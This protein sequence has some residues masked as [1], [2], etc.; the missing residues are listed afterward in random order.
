MNTPASHKHTHR[1]RQ[2][3][4]AN[5]WHLVC[6]TCGKVTVSGPLSREG[7]ITLASE[8]NGTCIRPGCN[9]PVYVPGEGH[10]PSRYKYCQAHL[11][12][13]YA[14]LGVYSPIVITE[15]G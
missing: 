10:Q 12:E 5:R 11:T 7:A 14:A 1:P 8:L 13:N 4:S 15:A 2:G 3:R 6:L 9:E